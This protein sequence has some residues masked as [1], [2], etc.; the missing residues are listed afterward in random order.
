MKV[1]I[2]GPITDHENY[3]EAFAAATAMLRGQ[4]YEV[5]S[6]V[7]L[8]DAEAPLV[9]SWSDYLRRD[10]IAL[11]TEC[12]AIYMLPGWSESRGAQLEHAV[13]RALD[14]RFIR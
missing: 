3:R 12:D 2:A 1:Y 8:D 14:M 11:L 10:L 13:A 7:E 5:I 6:P 9:R 4:G